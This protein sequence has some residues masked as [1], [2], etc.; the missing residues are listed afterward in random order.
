MKNTIISI[1]LFLSVLGF[2]MYSHYKLDHLCTHL[3]I[4]CNEIEELI[5][6]N[7]YEAAS[8]MTDELLSKIRDNHLLSSV[9]LNHSDFDM[10]SCEALKL[11]LYVECKNYDESKVALNLLKCYADNVRKL[12]KLNIENI[13]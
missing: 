13:F 11:S 7:S 3:E 12:H 6:S 9:Y 1:I 10:L 5:D 8:V 4:S 2:V